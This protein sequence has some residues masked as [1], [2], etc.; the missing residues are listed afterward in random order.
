ME[1]I[2]ILLADRDTS[3]LEITRKMLKFHN[4]NY[5]VDSAT[6]ASE[7]IDKINRKR[8]DLVLL[9]YD[10]GDMNGL[11]VIQDLRMRSI[12]VPVVL[13]VDEGKEEIAVKAVEQ[14][15]DDYIMKV[16]GYL[17]ALPFTVRK[18]LER[19]KIRQPEPAQPS[20]ESEPLAEQQK[21]LG[22]GYF[23]LDRSARFLSADPS[24][25]NLT[26]YSEEELFELR[27]GDL[28][29]PE[30]EQEL[31][32][33]LHTVPQGEAES[34]YETYLL[35][36]MGE[37]VR[38]DVSLIAMTDREGEVVNFRGRL[39][40]IPEKQFREPSVNGK[41]DQ[42]RMVD[43]LTDAMGESFE[44]PLNVLLERLAETL[45]QLFRFRHATVALL[46]RKKKVYVKQAMVG[47]LSH[48]GRPQRALEVPQEV[49][50]RIFARR[51]RVKV[52]YYNQDIRE[53]SE[54]LAPMVPERRSQRRRPPDQ[55][56][57]RDLILLNLTDREGRS[58]GYI[59]LDSPDEG[60]IPTRATFINLQIFGRLASFAI[61][62]YYRFASLERRSR[63]LKQVL[64]TSNIFKLYLSLGELLKE[65]VWSVKF[66][67][68][69]ELICLSLIS[70]K[71]GLLEIRSVACEDK[72]KLIQLLE[73]TFPLRPFSQ[74]LKEE[75][76][77]S[78]SYL[79]KKEEPVLRPLKQIYYGSRLDG[80]EEGEWSPVN[81]LL[82]PIRSR[83]GKI[84]GFLMVDD[85]VDGRMPQDEVIRTLEILANQVAVAI[86]NRVMYV[87]AKKRIRELETTVSRPV[88]QPEPDFN[89]HVDEE[90]ASVGIR[91]LVDKFFK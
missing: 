81:L 89:N 32:R 90:Y 25:E 84:I 37:R 41:F 57:E 21:T 68:D 79:I 12:Q 66:S 76:R 36:K 4:V 63:R 10:L 24:T 46:D 51:Y 40:R 18:V 42:V 67:L 34:H 78:K 1:A 56:H 53:P 22:D 35:T 31:Y 61:E 50:D 2:R 73:V 80:A 86:D 26:G 8:Y 64:V 75:Y 49:I 62:N 45:C 82:V 9:D 70:K 65:V 72:I 28:V 71:T 83:E 88:A 69:F 52:I 38:V 33:W 3:Y 30:S 20:K 59:S 85:P 60:H 48:N 13:M 23:I 55:W 11:Q 91:K 17:T 5:E 19:S 39:K 77:V 6:S 44:E 58:F 15:A 74:L 27:L 43:E 54:M 29:P 7:C 87:E 47:Y 14:G 16:R